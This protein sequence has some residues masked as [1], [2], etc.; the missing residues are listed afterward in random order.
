MVILTTL[1][2]NRFIFEDSSFSVEL[3]SVI[4]DLNSGES[5]R[6]GKTRR[7]GGGGLLKGAFGSW[8]SASAPNAGDVRWPDCVG[9]PGR[10]GRRGD[11]NVVR[12]NYL[13]NLARKQGTNGGRSLDDESMGEVLVHAQSSSLGRPIYFDE[14]EEVVTRRRR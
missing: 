3:P 5:Q 7:G 4:W 1:W 11:E 8:R 2:L 14:A 10:K 6:R 13:S 12:A 9:N